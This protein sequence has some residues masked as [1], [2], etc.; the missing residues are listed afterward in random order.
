MSYWSWYRGGLSHTGSGP[1]PEVERGEVIHLVAD[2]ESAANALTRESIEELDGLLDRIAVES[3]VKLVLLSSAKDGHFI[4]GADVERIGALTDPEEAA[5]LASTAQRVFGKLGEL[6]FPTIALIRGTCLGGG[7]ELALG[8]TH[9]IAVDD[10]RTRIGLP[11]VQLGIIPGFGGSQRLP[12]LIGIPKALPLILSGT[13]LPARAAW[14]RGVV[15][16]VVPSEGAIEVGLRAAVGL[17]ADG[18]RGVRRHRQRARGSLIERAIAGTALGR[19]WIAKKARQGVLARTGGHYPAP[20]AAIDLVIPA[21]TRPLA[22]GLAEEARV[23]GELVVSPVCKNLVGV[24]FASERARKLDGPAEGPE[25]RW[26]AGAQL[27]I[28][29][30]GV[31]GAGVASVALD[32]GLSVRLRDLEEGPLLRGLGQIARD[33]ERKVRRRRRTPREQEQLLARLTHTTDLQGFGRC[34]AVLE[35]IVE[36]MD[37]KQRALREIEP[38]LRE[39]CLFLTNTSA[40]SVSELQAAAELP[41]RVVG[42]HFFNPVPRM[43]LVEVVAGERTAPWAVSRAIGLAQALGKYPVVVQDSPGFVVN[44][45]LMPYLDAAVRLLEEGVPGPRIDAVARGFGLP[46]GPLRLIDEV[47]VD[48]GVEVARTLHEAFGDR[49]APSPLLEAMA[50][51]GW[52][53]CKSG[54]GFYRHDGKSPTWNADVSKLLPRVGAA[55]RSDEEIITA[56]VDPMVDEAAHCLDE[57]IVETAEAVDL[58]M[59]MGTG[60]PPFRGGLLRHADDSGLSAIV[61]RIEARGGARTPSELLVDLAASGETFHGAGLSPADAIGSA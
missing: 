13:R 15:D 61:A 18:G 19:A 42:L 45:L 60:F 35:A 49:V 7:L 14:K 40:L 46:M 21:T 51:E 55:D 36:R 50:A 37:I 57:G 53:G 27:G 6:P 25:G 16:A 1:A 8:C 29:G 56:L 31:M 54:R 28:L 11:E 3:A 5:A 44:R 4:A 52:L 17:L 26:P 33:G 32:R 23:V 20:L 34:D 38:S 43:P 22:E 39:D 41:E 48:I 59:V 30:A 10:P 47:G 24:F 58:A 9:R 2:G 12:R